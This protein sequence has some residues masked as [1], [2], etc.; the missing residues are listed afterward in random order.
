VVF[1]DAG[2]PAVL[3]GFCRWWWRVCE[4]L[5]EAIFVPFLPSPLRTDFVVG[6]GLRLGTI[7]G[8][9]GFGIWADDGLN[10]LLVVVIAALL[11]LE[12]LAYARRRGAPGER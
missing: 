3:D 7:A 10:T 12:V 9:L 1:P 5:R 8:F 2:L 11:L 6:I 4:G